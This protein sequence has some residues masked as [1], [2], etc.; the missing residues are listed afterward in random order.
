MNSTLKL[1]N[2]L[3]LMAAS[4]N[5]VEVHLGKSGKMKTCYM[6][7]DVVFYWKQ[8]VNTSHQM[9]DLFASIHVNL[10]NLN[11]KKREQFPKFPNTHDGTCYDSR[12]RTR[13]FF[14]A[15]QNFLFFSKIKRKQKKIKK[16][17][18]QGWCA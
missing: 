9:F 18:F 12:S 3:D 4:S 14:I 6:F 8:S 10:V 1:Q 16:F 17:S 13:I 2:F 15:S 5:F 11:K 7:L